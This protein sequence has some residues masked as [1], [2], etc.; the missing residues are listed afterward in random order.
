MNRLLATART[1]MPG[2][3]PLG[4][5]CL[6][7]QPSQSWST[8]FIHNPRAISVS[9][10]VIWAINEVRSSSS[11]RRQDSKPNNG[12][13]ISLYDSVSPRRAPNDMQITVRSGLVNEGHVWIWRPTWGRKLTSRTTRPIIRMCTTTTVR[14][15]YNNNVS[16]KQVTVQGKS[17]PRNGMHM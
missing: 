17:D 7:L 4:L 6:S 8:T 9:K 3:Y 16:D 5:V 14:H 1:R 13:D 15:V 11:S 12:R 10:H 2:R